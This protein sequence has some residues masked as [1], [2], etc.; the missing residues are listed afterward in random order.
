MSGPSD[1]IQTAP[2]GTV[3]D[4]LL[5]LGKRL[6]AELGL[7]DGV[8]TLGRWMAHYI[9][10]LIADV[11]EASPEDRPATED[12]CAAAILELWRHRHHAPHG[13]GRFGPEPLLRAIGSLDPDARGPRYLARGRK[14]AEGEDD[15]VNEWLHLADGIDAT[16]RMLVVQC[17]VAAADEAGDRSREWIAM[18]EAAGIEDDAP[19]AALRFLNEQREVIEIVEPD[20]ADQEML[21]R[22]LERLNVFLDLAQILHDK[23][24]SQIGA[25]A[26]SKSE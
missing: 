19:A 21:V 6:V 5:E 24:T 2:G 12:R 14:T 7:E 26:D 16:A 10:E 8:D 17:L 22:R 11:E 1:T 18:A 13:R 23:L 25:G 15:Q 3:S 4:A 20:Q 9:S